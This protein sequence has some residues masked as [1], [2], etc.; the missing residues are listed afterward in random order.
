MAS[1]SPRLLVLLFAASYLRAQPSTYVGSKACYACHTNIYR[2]F[3]K[4]DMGRSITAAREWNVDTLPPEAAVTQPGNSRIFRIFHNTSSWLQSET[5]P[6]V[7]TVEHQLDYA[8]G[9][10]SNGLTFLIQRGNHLFQA[11]LSYYSKLRKWDFSPGYEQL[12]LG[13]NRQVPE[14]C[15]GCH[16][17]RASPAIDKPGA[18]NDPP[19]RELSIGCENCHGPGSAHIKSAGKQPAAIVNPAKLNPRLAENIC[20]NC[21]QTGETRILQ[22]GKH[23]SDFQPGEWLFDTVVILKGSVQPADQNTDLLEHYSAM[24]SSRCFR[25][26]AGKLSCLT[27]HDPHLQPRQA[28]ISGYF[29]ARCLTCHTDQNCAVPLKLRAAQT[30]TD[31][32]VGCHMPK[33][34]VVQVSHSALTNHRILAR[35]GE[36]VAPTPPI[37]SEGLIIVNAPPGRAIQLAKTTL[38]QAYGEL[39][40]GNAEYRQRYSRLLEALSQVQPQDTLV[41]QALGHKAFIEDRFEEAIAH[42][43]LALPLNQPSIYLELAQSD[44]RLGRQSDAIEY[45]KTGVDLD[46]YN[47][48]MQK[49]L[50][51]QLINTN[52]YTEARRDLEHYVE[53][54]PEDSFMRDMLARVSK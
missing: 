26:S 41:Q 31:D 44:A 16:A 22:P 5:E 52:A 30:P 53:T 24:Q 1:L 13:F 3:K 34:K 50:I 35:E 40:Q 23:Y 17:G 18:F 27:C 38:L 49:V 2:S 11:P 33:R 10:G 8:V 54:F 14:E 6:G 4:T 9:S 47:A 32:C 43:K 36:P 21:H 45:L 48:V 19:F 37:E 28:E 20:M 42:L 25:E 7:Y 29:R 51:L 15:I 46:P 12:D 39:S